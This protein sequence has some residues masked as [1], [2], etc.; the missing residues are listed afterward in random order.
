MKQ[1]NVSL[2]LT[3][4]ADDADA[5]AAK[6]KAECSSM[7][8]YFVEVTAVGSAKTLIYEVVETVHATFLHD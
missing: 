7:T 2:N 1:F 6:A 4:D 3:V 8:A 5:A